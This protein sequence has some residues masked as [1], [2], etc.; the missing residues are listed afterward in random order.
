MK[1]NLIQIPENI[2]TINLRKD[3]YMED[4]KD[5]FNLM[6]DE[7]IL[8]SKIKRPLNSIKSLNMIGLVFEHL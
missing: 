6:V 7:I 4:K 3:Y 2:N 1:N 5:C 8:K